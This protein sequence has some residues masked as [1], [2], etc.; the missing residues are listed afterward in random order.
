MGLSNEKE[1]KNGKIEQTYKVYSFESV[2]R[3]VLANADTT[4]IIKPDEAKEVIRQIIKK[5]DL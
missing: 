1:L 5:L 2:A 4:T 3:W